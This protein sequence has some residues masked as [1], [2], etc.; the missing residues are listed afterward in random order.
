MY[1]RRK[2]LLALL[3][4]FGGSLPST[5]CEKLL[6]AFRQQTTCPYWGKIST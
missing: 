4:V 6:F 1:Y 5:D 2:I 3:E